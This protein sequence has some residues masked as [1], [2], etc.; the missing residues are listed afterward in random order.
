MDGGRRAVKAFIFTF[1]PLAALLSGVLGVSRGKKT[2]DYPRRVRI[3][4]R[5]AAE[6][7]IGGCSAN[8][9]TNRVFLEESKPDCK[10]FAVRI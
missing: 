8:D 2:R 1:L 3:A 7:Q 9:Y 5:I 6:E 4:D 10:V